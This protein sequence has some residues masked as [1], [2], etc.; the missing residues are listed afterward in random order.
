MVHIDHSNSKS[1]PIIAILAINWKK[2]KEEKFSS[3]AF[4]ELIAKPVHDIAQNNFA[5]KALGDMFN[6]N[7]SNL[8]AF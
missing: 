4:D 3:D 6:P 2:L 5:Y 8:I 7:P 1:I